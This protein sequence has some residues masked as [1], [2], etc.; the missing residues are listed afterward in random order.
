MC[1]V[2]R[3]VQ[4]MKNVKPCLEKSYPTRRVSPKF[5]ALVRVIAYRRST[6]T[7]FR[8][9]VIHPGLETTLGVV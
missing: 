8:I 4:Y 6:E 5:E 1:E 2:S 7:G 9:A 3:F